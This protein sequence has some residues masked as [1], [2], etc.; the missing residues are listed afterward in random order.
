MVAFDCLVSLDEMMIDHIPLSRHLARMGMS[1]IRS[2]GEAR[3]PVLFSL[4]H[5]KCGSYYYHF[6][7]NYQL[8]AREH[9][10][11]KSMAECA[12]TQIMKGNEQSF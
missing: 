12:I 2:R 10:H 6:G 5:R 11:G 8:G 3:L 4:L 7:Y 9:I 1:L